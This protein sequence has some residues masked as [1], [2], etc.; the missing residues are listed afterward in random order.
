[1]AVNAWLAPDSVSGALQYACIPVPVEQNSRI[2]FMGALY[3]LSQPANWQGDDI[4]IATV[5]RQY[6]DALIV[7][8]NELDANL[9]NCVPAMPLCDILLDCI[10]TTPEI[11]AKIKE[12]SGQ[13]P[14]VAER[15]IDPTTSSQGAYVTPE[16][17]AVTGCDKDKLWGAVTK[18]VDFIN[19]TNEDF[20]EN[21]SL[22]SE[23]SDKLEA[24]VDA[25]PVAG[26][27]ANIVVNTITEVGDDLLA[28]YN[29]SWNDT[30]RDKIAC[31]LFCIAQQNSCALKL[32]HISQYVLDRYNLVSQAGQLPQG[33]NLAILIAK[34]ATVI[35]Q[36]GG[37][38]YSGD[39]L[40]YVMFL[41]QMQAV[42]I[43]D[44]YFYIESSAAYYQEAL[45]SVPSQGWSSECDDCGISNC[46]Y[47][48]L[49]QPVAGLIV[50]E[51]FYS[52]EGLGNDPYSIAG[53]L[54]TG[55]VFD[56]Y[57]DPDAVIESVTLTYQVDKDRPLSQ[58]SI[59]TIIVFGASGTEIA[60]IEGYSVG[61]HTLTFAP[62]TPVV[63]SRIKIR[64][65]GS[66]G[67]T[68]V[69][70]DMTICVVT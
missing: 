44:K 65:Q 8:G 32:E 70:R 36:G 12:V 47:N 42:A 56:I 3:L 29:A 59:A 45:D 53:E 69:V 31:D 19:Q 61:T 37:L 10:N 39:D 46:V 25:I 68:S 5:C 64:T 60:R 38:V 16:Y 34:I 67:F 11:Q 23:L 49:T 7:V 27:V 63:A 54:V 57:Y 26:A 43:A 15:P 6:L 33:A 41:L 52:D 1:M 20:L 30:L 4:V 51:G 2:A 22:F 9:E 13:N 58:L 18:M 55:C 21:L 17:P 35:A 50:E 40:V 62:A 28:S 66:R 48:S 24:W 14:I